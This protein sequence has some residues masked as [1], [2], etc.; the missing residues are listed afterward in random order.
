MLESARLNDTTISLDR[1]V[2]NLVV[3][4]YFEMR[5]RIYENLESFECQNLG[6]YRDKKITDPEVEYQEILNIVDKVLKQNFSIL[7]SKVE[8]SIAKNT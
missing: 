7:V 5:G 1:I 3:E 4:N 2:V 8:S 6:I